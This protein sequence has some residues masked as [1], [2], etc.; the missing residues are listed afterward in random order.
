M[1][2]LTQPEVN[3]VAEQ[4]VAAGQKV[5]AVE[6]RKAIKAVRGTAPSF[7][8][9][10][11]LHR[12][13]K[14]LK[15][16]SGSTDPIHVD[17]PPAI[18]ERSDS[19]MVEMWAEATKMANEKLTSEREALNAER[20]LLKGE[21]ADGLVEMDKVQET[22]DAANDTLAANTATIATLT[23][24]V[25]ALNTERAIL[26]DKLHQAETARDE[27]QRQIDAL[28]AERQ[29][30]D[31]TVRKITEQSGMQSQ[32]IEQLQEQVAQVKDLEKSNRAFEKNLSVL[33]AQIAGEK[34]KASDATQRRDAQEAEIKNLHA[35]VR[36]LN[37]QLQDALRQQGAKRAD[38]KTA[39]LPATV[40]A[41]KQTPAQA[42]A[43][44]VQ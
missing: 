23:A 31:A 5:T 32:K 4:M 13:W 19:V 17:V 3:V 1:A 43:G 14:K 28:T 16:I 11:P 10:G 39:P 25:A 44:K 24:D 26:T 34:V 38:D 15:G 12:D 22:L 27:R 30:L 35:Q 40:K 20:E 42:P 33:E 7:T 29:V 9:L 6:L 36:D 2:K 21:V 37:A 8:D 18:R 41:G